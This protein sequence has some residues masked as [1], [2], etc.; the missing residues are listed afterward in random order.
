MTATQIQTPHYRKTK[1]GQW[2]VAGPSSMIRDGAQ[3][4]VVKRDGN[5]KVERI[6]SV[7][8]EYDDHGVKCRYGYIAQRSSHSSGG[9]R[10]SGKRCWETGTNCYSYGSAY[11]EECGDHM[12]R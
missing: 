5:T 6:A 8:R 1:D 7:G 3:V 10:E 2:V 9:V 4:T 12:Y 11:C